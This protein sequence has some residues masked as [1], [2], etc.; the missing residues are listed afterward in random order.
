MPWPKDPAARELAR[1]RHRT[2]QQRRW[3]RPGQ[4]EHQREKAVAQW[5][6]PGAKEQM[7]D[8]ARKDYA[9][10]PERRERVSRALRGNLN[11]ISRM[12]VSAFKRWR[13]KRIQSCVDARAS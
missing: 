12:T 6:E 13:R 7:S 10:R 8:N 11:W 1:E 5:A 9:Q 3:Q 4:R 2:A